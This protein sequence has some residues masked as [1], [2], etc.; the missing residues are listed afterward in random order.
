MKVFR[1][2]GRDVQALAPARAAVSASM[3]VFRISG[4]DLTR[5]VETPQS[6]LPQ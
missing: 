2:S 1:I 5:S 3:K 6:A 4:R